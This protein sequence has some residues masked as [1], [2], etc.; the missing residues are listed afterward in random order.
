MLKN[1]S[2]CLFLMLFIVT[3]VSVGGCSS[4]KENSSANATAISNT[5]NK[6][7]E[8]AMKNNEQETTS[9]QPAQAAE[10]Q[11]LYNSSA[12]PMSQPHGYFNHGFS[13]EKMMELSE[14]ALGNAENSPE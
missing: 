3:G 13:D 5:K 9:S 11:S 14:D 4:K 6:K 7:A 12:M 1:L 8:S 10:G 2:A